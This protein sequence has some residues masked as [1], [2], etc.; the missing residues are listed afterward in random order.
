M[1]QNFE[2]YKEYLF[3]SFIDIIIIILGATAKYSQQYHTAAGLKFKS[4]W[5]T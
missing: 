2:N 3:L 5:Q 4:C 1:Q